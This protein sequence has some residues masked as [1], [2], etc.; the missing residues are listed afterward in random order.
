M[1]MEKE[2]DIK[3]KLTKI[4]QGVVPLLLFIFAIALI[5]AIPEIVIN[6]PLDSPLYTANNSV[7]LNFSISEPSLNSLIYHWNGTNYTFYDPTLILMYNFDNVSSLGET[8]SKAVDS[9]RYSNNGTMTGVTWSSNGKYGYAANFGS[10]NNRIIAS[11]SINLFGGGTMTAWA[12]ADSFPN[13]NPRIFGAVGNSGD[14]IWILNGINLGTSMNISGT[15]QMITTDYIFPL[16]RWVFVA[17][18]FNQSG[19]NIYINGTKIYTNLSPVY[20][21]T[22]QPE[23]GWDGVNN[24]DYWDG[25]IDEVRIWNRSLSETEIYQQYVSNL[26]KFNSTQWNFYVNQSKNVTAGLENGTYTY[27]IFATNTSGNLNSTEQRTIIIGEVPDTTYPSF[28]SYSD[29]NASLSGSGTAWFNATIENTNGTA[30][31]TFNNINYTATNLTSNIYNVSVSLT[32]AGT[33][34]YS[35]YAYGNGSDNLLNT[36]EIIIYLVN[37]SVEAASPVEESHPSG[38]SRGSYISEQNTQ[39]DKLNILTWISPNKSITT[40]I[41]EDKGTGIMEIE[42]K[43]K[44]WL[45]GAIYIVA[46]NETPDFCPMG[47]LEGHKVYK[48]LNFNNTLKNTSLDF[49]RFK[50]GVDK[51]WIYGNNISE[52]KFVRCSPEYEE[53]RSSF[54]SETDSEGIYNV[55]V[56]SFS[57]Y[58]ILGTYEKNES[59][60]A[61]DKK[62]DDAEKY[63]S[64]FFGIFL[65]AVGGIFL[66]ALIFILIKHKISLK[67]KIHSKFFDFEFKFRLGR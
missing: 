37:E 51:D 43:S 45:S 36:S 15:H 67:E 64:N 30:G 46:Y 17:M 52:I 38:G 26:N 44:D 19:L 42:L 50:I 41:R 54:E 48:I 2:Q 59:S 39:T 33:Y 18:T 6:F 5:S 23:I 20:G 25:L 7:I 13:Y 61:E 55:Y 65:L 10:V 27:Q 63:S 56:S 24:I 8:S 62:N 57:A 1:A 47:Y 9:S 35:W 29:N 14:Q 60:F 12:Y 3:I 49:G 16:S 21:S 4:K 58:A 40:K 31:I 66:A 53:V 34:N 11:N 28:S 22:Y 32:S